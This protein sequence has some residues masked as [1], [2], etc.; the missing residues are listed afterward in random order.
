MAGTVIRRNMNKPIILIVALRYEIDGDLE[1]A[2]RM[3]SRAYTPREGRVESAS[4][5]KATATC[6]SMQAEIEE[7]QEDMC[8][9]RN[10]VGYAYL[11]V[12]YPAGAAGV[13]Q[14]KQRK[15]K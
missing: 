11:Q 14:Q 8:E 15:K 2:K 13:Q 4:S 9:V 5:H 3:L 6:I 7:M 12:P 1:D 10:G